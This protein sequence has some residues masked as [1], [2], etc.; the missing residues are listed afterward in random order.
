M[1]KL[2]LLAIFGFAGLALSAQQSKQGVNAM[3]MVDPS[4]IPMQTQANYAYQPGP[5]T[6][7]ISGYYQQ[8]FEGATFPPAGCRVDNVAGPT[9][10]WARSTAQ[11]HL[12][13]A[14]AFIR[15]DAAAGGGQD[16]LM[17][18]R[19]LVTATTDSV[20]FWMRLAFAG[21]QPDS[22][23]IKISTTDSLTSSFTTTL[24]HLREGTNY[25]TNTTT[26]YRYAVSLSAY[27][28][29]QIYVAFKHY[30]VDG[31]GLYVDDV[32]IGTPP[33]TEVGA[34]A[35]ISPTS[36]VGVGTITPQASFKNFGTATQSF[37]V[38]TT[39]NPGGYT[40]T[41]SVSALAPAATATATFAPWTATAGT[42]T[43]K[44]Y[45]D[46]PGDV[47]RYND[48]ITTIITVVP[49]FQQYGW[50]VMTALPGGRWAT[51]PVFAKPCLSSTD[52]GYIYLIS[53]GDA[54]F[55]NTTLNTR[56]NTVTGAYSTLAPIPQSRTQISPVY[57]NGKIYVIGGYGA[58]FSPVNTNSIYD[59]ATNTWTTGAPMPQP[60][61]DYAV[62]LYNDSLIYFVGGYSGSVDV[63]TVQ[64]Y[65][66][67]TN[68]WV[69]GT[70]KTGTAVAGCRMG[71]SGNKI[72][73]M[74]GYSQTLAAT[75]STAVLGTINT[76]AP[77][78]ITWS[79]LPNYPAGPAGRHG[80]GVA[81]QDN[82][83]V[84]FAGG[85]PN[86]QGTQ[87]ITAAYAYNTILSQWEVGPNMPV[88][89]SNITN[90]AGIIANDS[91]SMVTM[92]GYNGSVVVSSN[93]WLNIGPAAPLPTGPADVAICNGSSTTLTAM[94]AMSYVWSPAT[95]L[96]S[97][98]TASTVANPSSTITYT[99]TMDKG[100]GCPVVD[101]VTVT[102][103]PLPAVVANATA[104][105]VC[106]GSPVTL[107]GSGT[108][109][110]YTW[111]NSV[112]DNVA[113]TPAATTTYMVTGTDANGCTNTDM[114]TVTVNALPT[115]VAN[116]TATAVCDGSP[117]TLTGSGAASYTWDNSVMDNVAFNPAAT[118]TYMVTGTDAN[119]CTNTD[120]VTV[121][122]NAL[123]T[124][125]ANA[126][127]PAVCNG[128]P[129]TLTGSGATS[130]TWDNSVM[131]GVAFNPSA[132]T[133]YMVTG[134]DANGCQDMDMI[135]VT[136]NALPT[137]V[138][139]ATA[140]TVCENSPVTLSGSGAVSYTWDNSVMDGVAFNPAATTT[141][142]VTGTDANGCTATDMITV[143]VNAAPAVV[144]NATATA[145]CAGSP[146]VLTGSGA[147]SYTWTGSVTDNVSFVPTSTN[148][149]TV[150]GTDANGCTN[151]DEIT[152]TV[153]PLP[154]VT[155]AIPTS[156]MCVDDADLTLTGG[157]PAGGTWNG[158]GISGSTF[159]P[160]T[161]GA[162]TQT[163]T[164]FFTDAN[165]CDGS[166]TDVITVS[167]CTGIAAVATGNDFV[168]YPNP[169]AG[170]F[171]IQ[172]SSSPTTAVNVEVLNALGQVV[173]AFTMTE[174]SK[175]INIAT[176][177]NGVYFVR[178]INGGTV[179]VQR[180]VK[181]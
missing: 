56:Y 122:V 158:P 20:T 67:Y 13:T 68:T 170:E 160:M 172:L 73:L 161:A 5:T 9:Y 156:T 16:W 162:G 2:T 181:Q 90:L 142:M 155:L 123:P 32:T 118:T 78:T 127:A 110:S 49:A 60:V 101:P 164:Y 128:S 44:T 94:N 120:M 93:H 18:P 157:S 57:V 23:C 7:T 53:G 82:G 168:I 116:A 139:N 154:N 91:L 138:A 26:W 173:D 131:D 35:L 146:V 124:V 148:T 126:T 6:Q 99:V 180:I 81:F 51:G 27:N 25:P 113:F 17:M 100:Y 75:Q 129:V 149:Y 87:V 163:I 96:S 40:S 153:N 136:V 42:Y 21:Y 141:Y 150:T 71:I 62:G 134:T 36:T 111:D 72:V 1:K 147:V 48:T 31:D 37:N 43:L 15:Y 24:L 29:Q 77:A 159:D 28:G 30:N 54:S 10:T 83:L 144:A 85:D 107:S 137:V 70:P 80:A 121:T 178:V 59:I 64:I 105:A 55:A 12:S 39:I 14:S 69:A 97:T 34:F 133:T 4:L 98:T 145:V 171:N 165:G 115:V 140:T 66:T 109:T 89:V 102:V 63:N 52:T 92:G 130:Y 8:G 103:N 38:V 177:D 135:T 47:N 166:A 104:S 114:V 22:L 86:G 176:L 61:G 88:G 179:T 151:T 175:Q 19:Y 3:R 143:N 45:S 152:V 132:T 108:A 58:S 106:A 84:Y 74:G 33:S 76:A 125:V 46:L 50:D 167:L 112:M 117:V 95:N 169:N 79:A 119:G 41:S 11:A 174:A 65:N